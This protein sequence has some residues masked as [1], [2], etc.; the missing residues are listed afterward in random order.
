MAMYASVI[1]FISLNCTAIF[2]GRPNCVSV[3]FNNGETRICIFVG[4]GRLL[5]PQHPL[6]KR[7]FGAESMVKKYTGQNE[8]DP[9]VLHQLSSALPPGAVADLL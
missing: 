1:T 3:K 2:N 7:I 9:V 6:T 4:R 8:D 5:A